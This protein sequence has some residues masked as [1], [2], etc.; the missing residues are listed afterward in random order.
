[1]KWMGIG[2]A[3]AAAAAVLV[4]GTSAGATGT[5]LNGWS[6][7]ST[8]HRCYGSCLY[9]HAGALGAIYE[10]DAGAPGSLAGQTFWDDHAGYGTNSSQGAGQAVSSNAGSMESG[11]NNCDVTTWVGAYTGDYNWVHAL[12]GGSLTTTLHNH[13]TYLGLG[14]CT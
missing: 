10:Y 12:R 6:T 5:L 11:Y 9:Y 13:E 4:G 8:P 1:V 3:T 14:T 2:V 7:V